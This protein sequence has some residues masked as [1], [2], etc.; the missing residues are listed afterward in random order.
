[1]R[2]TF[3]YTLMLTVVLC[4][5]LALPGMAQECRITG[6]I[7]DSR[8]AA[9]PNAIVIVTH[10]YTGSTRQVLS[11]P[12]GHF[13]LMPTPP[14]EYR[15]E[16]LKPGFRPLV[17]TGTAQCSASTADLHLQLEEANVSGVL[18]LEAQ[19]ADDGSLLAY[20]CGLA[21]GSGCELVQPN[22]SGAAFDATA[23]NAIVP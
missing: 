2:C 21:E 14:G 17:R 15:I 8:Q 19:K 13:Q 1:M 3:T 9:I 10:V 20:I 7:T 16:A 6:H 12:H 18:N 22:G 23:V 11:N 4:P 5:W